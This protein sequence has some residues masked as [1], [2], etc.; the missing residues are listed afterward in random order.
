MTPA[1]S[2]P[3]PAPPAP[4]SIDV[5]FLIYR[6]CTLCTAFF[7]GMHLVMLLDCRRCYK[8]ALLCV[9]AVAAFFHTSDLYFQKP[10][11]YLL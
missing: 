2:L 7:F 5:I 3:S 10:K 9:F 1:S 8:A 6:G 4:F 11:L